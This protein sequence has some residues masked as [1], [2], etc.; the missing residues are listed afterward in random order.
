MN[1]NVNND[2]KNINKKYK[3][4]KG[5]IR[6][7]IMRQAAS[8]TLLSL[9][10]VGIVY[11]PLRVVS[12]PSDRHFL[13]ENKIFIYKWLSIGDCFWVKLLVFVDD[14]YQF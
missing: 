8:K 7:D 12:Y 11:L 9:L 14:L 3:G 4:N 1:Y 2:K 13:E 10:R 6:D 5:K